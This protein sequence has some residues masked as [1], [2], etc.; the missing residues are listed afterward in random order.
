MKKLSR[1]KLLAIIFWACTTTLSA[2][3]YKDPQNMPVE[4][5]NTDCHK[6]PETFQ[7]LV[8]AIRLIKASRF[9]YQQ[10]F[11]TTRRS[12]LME[13]S[14][15]SCDFKSGYLIVR[16]DGQDHLYTQIPV[17]MWEQFRQTADI[18]G[19]Y[20]NKIKPLAEITHE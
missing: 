20:L 2:Q 1:F 14:Y 18:D 9:G 7:D 19:F 12:G 16:F 13:A 10:D 15:Y 8:E 6:L 3:D 17:E 11:K 4:P 5:Q